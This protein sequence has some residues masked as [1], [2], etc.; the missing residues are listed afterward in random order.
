MRSNKLFVAASSTVVLV[1]LGILVLFLVR[2]IEPSFA[3]TFPLLVGAAIVFTLPATP[4]LVWGIRAS[5]RDPESQPFFLKA[6][7]VGLAFP[8]MLFVAG[9]GHAVFLSFRGR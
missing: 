1:F 5:K 6:L 7:L 3:G 4:L 9:L 2:P 8:P